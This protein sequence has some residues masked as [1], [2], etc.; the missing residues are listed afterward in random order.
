MDDPKIGDRVRATMNGEDWFAGVYVEES[1]TLAQ[2]GVKRDDTGEVRYFTTAVTYEHCMCDACKDGVIHWSD[3]AVHNEPAYPNGSCDCCVT[4]NA[5]VSGA[6]TASAG[7]PGSVAVS[8]EKG[9]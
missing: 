1:E 4:P 3:C 5:K 2:Y 6:G 9:D 8:P 7:L